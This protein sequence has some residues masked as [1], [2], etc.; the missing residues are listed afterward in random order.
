M[1]AKQKAIGDLLSLAYPYLSELARICLVLPH[2]NVD[3]EHLF[4]MVGKIE[5]EIVDNMR[6]T[7]GKNEKNE[8]NGF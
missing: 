6:P 8:S 5:I 2:S 7:Y 3:P 1:V 4:S